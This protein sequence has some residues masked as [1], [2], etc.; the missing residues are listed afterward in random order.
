[1]GEIPFAARMHR[2]GTET[3]FEVLARA[4]ALEAQGR[5]V[6][7]LEI[8]EP[9]FATP[10]HIVAAAKDALDAGFT[11]YVPTAGLPEVRAA[12]A[13]H[14]AATRG[15][16]VAPEQ[17]V[18]T[19]GAKPI[20]FFAALMLCQEGD[21]A[22]VPDPGFPIYASVI[23]YS[24]ARPVPLRLRPEMGFR[25]DLDELR[26]RITDRTRLLILN[27]PHNPTGAIV[28]AAD[29]AAIADMVRGRP[30]T[31]LSDEIY[32][33]LLYDGDFASIASLPGMAEQT[34]ILDGFSKTY[35]M[36]GWRLGY[37]VMPRRLAEGMALL[38]VNSASCTAAFTQRA[39]LA[40][41]TGPQDAALAM[42]EEFRARRD[43]IVAG[44]NAVPG[45]ACRAPEGAFYAFP[46]VRGTGLGSDEL[47]ARLLG[48][49]GVAVLAGSAFGAG[50][51]GFLRL[52]YANSREN[53]ARAV[54][55]IGAL[56]AALP[57]GAASA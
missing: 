35:A 19:P 7:H 47:A 52:S 53:I 23:A 42:R 10:A 18:I 48:E 57:A 54:E 17:V 30:I 11:H 24:G 12:I 5:D 51:E 37:G 8:G 32:S 9:D 29:L 20:M 25:L 13:A 41:L 55:R 1:M 45:V 43:L 3:A 49:A 34:I 27:S 36:T 46:D 39:G 50:G 56:V 21:E 26:A 4:R 31:V 6:I 16:A 40:A 44:L 38:M 2:L 22:L 33:G 15:I 14:I 28:P